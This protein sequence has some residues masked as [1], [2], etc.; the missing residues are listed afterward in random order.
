MFA[1]HQNT[2]PASDANYLASGT[3]S[4]WGVAAA[5][6]IED[7]L[8]N[9]FDEPVS[10]TICE[11]T[12][13]ARKS[14]ITIRQLL[15]LTSG[16]KEDMKQLGG[17]EG[18]AE[19]KYAFAISLPAVSEPGRRFRYGPSHF[20]VFGEVMK[21]KLESRGQ[22]P[23]DYL[24]QRILDPLDISIDKWVHDHA[25]NPHIPNGAYVAASDWAKF[26]VFLL[27]RSCSNSKQIV[28]TDLLDECFKGSSANPGYGLTFWLNQ[29]GGMGA[30]KTQRAPRGSIAG[31]IYSDAYPDLIGA[32]GSGRTRMY[33]IPSRQLVIVRQ[34]E[35]KKADVVADSGFLKKILKGNNALTKLEM[36]SAHNS[37]QNG[38]SR[39][40]I[41]SG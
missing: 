29:P 4:F 5:A 22:T 38:E 28:R 37:G 35:K 12:G 3:K 33:I 13:D 18:R 41:S 10:A 7:G 15:S 1:H 26:G 21:R 24:K 16:L 31:W 39:I 17:V 27:Q 34:A 32:L 36:A 25:G 6:M 8:I 14:R 40:I 19:D 23:L 20:Y 9:S 2:G 30:V 11:W